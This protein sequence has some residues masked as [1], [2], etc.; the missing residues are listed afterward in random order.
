MAA[1]RPARGLALVVTALALAL[2][3]AASA[4]GVTYGGDDLRTSW[5]PDQASLT[6][7]LVT[8]GTFGRL[9]S[10]PVDGQVYAQPLMSN[11][12]LFVAT[13]SDWI[14]GL[15]PVTGAQQ[16]ARNVGTPWNP[17]DV[18]C[19]DL[20]PT[21]GIT[22]T[23]VI[24]GATH[25]AYFFAKTYASG[26]S[27]PAVWKMHAVDTSTGA[28]RGGFPVQIGGEAQNRPGATFDPTHEMQR[29]GLLLMDGV[30]YAAFGGHCDALPYQGWV[31]G[32]STSGAVK[33]RWA[34]APNYAGIWQSGGGVVSDG[35]GQ[36]VV[37]TGNGYGPTG[38]LLGTDPP[39]NLGESVVRLSVQSDGSLRATDFFSPYDAVS[40]DDWDGDLGSGGPLALPST[41][42]GTSSYPHLLV[43]AGKEGYVYLLDRD[44]LGGIAEGASGGDAVV[45]RI[46]PY[47]GVWSR[48]A[49]WPGD[50]GYVYM[51]TASP[52]ADTPGLSYGGV[53]R[54]YRYG[55]DGSG[56]PTLALA[57]TS[58]D[59]Y[60]FGS[61]GPVVTSDGTSSGS[62]IVWILWSSDSTG[63]GA[64]LR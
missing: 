50:G 12:T 38:P 6:P 31:F 58:T 24:D 29:P 55:V 1:R 7:Q 61:G 52:S 28:E 60:G 15:D 26:T 42:F 48:P 21:I 2:P 33:A 30:V 16:W 45:A 17:A 20:T 5:Y 41:T 4:A 37:A 46:G 3:A 56:K 39:G 19:A 44:H 47:G 9:F 8:G 63:T 49:V 18:G 62:A 51:P 54:A 23:P 22:G 34:S 32:V 35:S 53:L 36:I 43:I 25:T 11:G 14:Y 10:A 64:Q 40:L 57:G 27:G 59:V 13:E